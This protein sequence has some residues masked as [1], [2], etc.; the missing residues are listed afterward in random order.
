MGWGDTTYTWTH[1][2]RDMRCGVGDGNTTYMDSV[3]KA[4][5]NLLYDTYKYTHEVIQHLQSKTLIF[6]C[7]LSS[8]L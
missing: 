6:Y 1:S 5:V 8:L 3:L 4:D 2:W 7:A